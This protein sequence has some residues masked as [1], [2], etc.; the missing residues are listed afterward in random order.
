MNVFPFLVSSAQLIGEFWNIGK[1]FFQRKYGNMRIFFLC[2]T[3]PD[4]GVKIAAPIVYVPDSKSRNIPEVVL[5]RRWAVRVLG[6]WREGVGWVKGGQMG[7][8]YKQPETEV[9]DSCYSWRVPSK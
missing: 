5:V 6:I 2:R 7:S 3:S 9:D 1:A 4:S 8:V